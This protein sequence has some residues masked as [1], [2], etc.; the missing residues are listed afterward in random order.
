[1]QQYIRLYKTIQHY[2]IIYK[3]IRHYTT[4]TT[5]YKTI[6][7][8]IRLCD[9]IQRYTTLYKT[10]QQYIKLYNT[11][12][13]YTRPGFEINFCVWL[14]MGQPQD[15]VWLPQHNFGCPAPSPFSDEN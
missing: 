8:Y 15:L 1:M 3:D 6:Q 2:T 7:H 5:L 13:C 12:Q 4:H 9:T 11:I 14:S 10:I